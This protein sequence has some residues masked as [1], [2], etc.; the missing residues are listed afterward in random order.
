MT[1]QLADSGL[2]YL[3]LNSH[4]KEVGFLTVDGLHYRKSTC[5]EIWNEVNHYIQAERDRDAEAARE[6]GCGMPE[7]S[8]TCSSWTDGS[9]T[10][11]F[12]GGGDRRG[13]PARRGQLGPGWQ[14]SAHGFRG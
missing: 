12:C 1:K 2:D 4:L 6:A 7:D 8:G 9:Y 3:D 13:R 14:G 11:W 10:G 5:V